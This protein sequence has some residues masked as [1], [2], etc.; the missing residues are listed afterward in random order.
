MWFGGGLDLHRLERKRN[1]SK[2]GG[3]QG[4]EGVHKPCGGGVLRWVALKDGGV[5]GWVA[6]PCLD[7]C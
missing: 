1:G 7:G 2:V 5:T 3:G 6:S 4:E